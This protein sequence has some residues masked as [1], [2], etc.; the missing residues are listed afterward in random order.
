[1]RF[2]LNFAGTFYTLNFQRN[3]VRGGAGENST[4][5]STVFHYTQNKIA[6]RCFETSTVD[7]QRLSRYKVWYP[8]WKLLLEFIG[9]TTLDRWIIL[10]CRWLTSIR[11]NSQFHL[12]STNKRVHGRFIDTYRV[13]ST[14]GLARGFQLNPDLTKSLRFEK[15]TTLAER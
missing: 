7:E 1:M 12:H 8:L 14:L 9:N 10:L 3:V 2:S 15:R 11:C 13:Y 4:V 5:V 6:S